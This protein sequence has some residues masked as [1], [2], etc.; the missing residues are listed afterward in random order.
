MQGLYI[1]SYSYM[2]CCD[3]PV[4]TVHFGFSRGVKLA[5]AEFFIY[6]LR[7]SN[8]LCRAPGTLAPVVNFITHKLST[9]ASLQVYMPYKTSPPVLLH[10]VCVHLFI[11]K[12]LLIVP[13]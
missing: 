10:F 8:L 5:N 6:G 11:P 4:C 2:A 13:T 1:E 3:D 7:L 12:H 9:H